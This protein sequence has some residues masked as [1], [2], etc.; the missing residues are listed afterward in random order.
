MIFTRGRSSVTGGQ[1][2]DDQPDRLGGRPSFDRAYLVQAPGLAQD[3]LVYPI[4]FSTL[5]MR[6][7]L[8]HLAIQSDR[9]RD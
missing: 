1:P 8:L 4:R 3:L 7:V 6:V 5:C 2:R 9:D